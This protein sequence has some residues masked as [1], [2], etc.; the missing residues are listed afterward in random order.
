VD[1][2]NGVQWYQFD[3]TK[4]FVW[5]MSKI[6]FTWDLRRTPEDRRLEVLKRVK[7]AG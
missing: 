5:T 2:R 3:P 4:W 7:A 1:Y 6:G